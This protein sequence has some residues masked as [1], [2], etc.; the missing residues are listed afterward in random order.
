MTCDKWIDVFHY[1]KEVSVSVKKISYLVHF[2]FAVLD[3]NVAI[4]CKFP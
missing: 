2:A 1:F 3:L 4:K